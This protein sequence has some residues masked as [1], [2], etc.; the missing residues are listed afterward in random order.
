[1]KTA[2]FCSLVLVLILAASSMLWADSANAQSIAMPT[3]PGIFQVTFSSHPYDVAPKTAID[4]YTGETVITEGGYHNEN[5]TVELTIKNQPLSPYTDDAGHPIGLYYKINF[6]GHYTDD[7]SEYFQPLPASSAEYTV[8]SISSNALN[9]PNGGRMDF[10]IQAGIGYVTSS[11]FFMGGYIYTL[12]GET[13]DLSAI[14]TITLPESASTLS[15]TNPP[16]EPTSTPITPSESTQNQTPVPT[17]IQPDTQTG[18][19]FGLDFGEK[20]P[21]LLWLWWLLFWRWVWL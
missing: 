14:Q 2:T 18:A 17:P 5:K 8:L 15:P 16:S 6:K 21:L 1:M 3:T 19:T 7:W 20:L 9:A 10:R 11:E 13:S 4:P 12:N